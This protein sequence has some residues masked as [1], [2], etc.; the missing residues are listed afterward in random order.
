MN[1]L[2]KIKKYLTIEVVV[3][4]LILGFCVYVYFKYDSD[5]GA[6]G[7]E[8][9]EGGNVESEFEYLLR[10]AVISAHNSPGDLP[11]FIGKK[12]K[13]GK[14][15]WTTEEEC[16]KIFEGI[17]G[18]KFPSCRPLFL[19]NPATGQNLELDGYCAEL[20]LAF[21]YDG[22]QHAKYIPHFHRHGPTEFVYQV[23]KDDYKTK[24]C[25]AEGIDL[26]RIPHYIHR[27]N[28]KEFIIRR[29]NEIGRMP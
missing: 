4:I 28:L 3:L 6:Y 19:R 21:E 10:E 23:A 11:N 8:Y 16:R 9:D 7:R 5:S 1:L 2:H 26:V 14:K 29:L 13:K 15:K 17:F 18:R 27:E 12:P 25:I 24:K 20:H 22:G